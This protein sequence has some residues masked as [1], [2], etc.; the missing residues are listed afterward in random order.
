MWPIRRKAHSCFIL[1]AGV[2]RRVSSVRN[3]SELLREV[4]FKMFQELFG[5]VYATRIEMSDG[6]PLLKKI[7]QQLLE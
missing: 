4:L 5:R 3:G 1:F 6:V 7:Y 2:S